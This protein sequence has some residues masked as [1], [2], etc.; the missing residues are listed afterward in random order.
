MK[1]LDDIRK[2]PEETR[3]ILFGLSVFIT[4]LLVGAIWFHS[5]QKNLY[6]LLNSEEDVQKILAKEDNSVPSLFALVGQSVGDLKG[7]ISDFL[8]SD[9]NL[10]N[11]NSSKDSDKT[12]S[13]KVYVLPLSGSK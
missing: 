4:V 13:G 10:N 6:V 1:L 7:L 2:Q 11:I 3:N 12:E 5:F 9:G 8:N